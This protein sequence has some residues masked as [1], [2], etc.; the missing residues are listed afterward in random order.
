MSMLSV[1]VLCDGMRVFLQ[2]QVVRRHAVE[3]CSA[4][5]AS[6]V[7]SLVYTA[8]LAASLGLSGEIG[9]S[10][11]PRSITVALA[12][13]ISQTLGGVESLTAAMVCA[14]GLT[15]AA[16]GQ[17]VLGMLRVRDEISRGVA[18]ASSAHGLGASAMAASEPQALPFC[19][20]TIVIMGTVSNVLV[21]MP[22]F[23]SALQAVTG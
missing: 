15:G 6:S 13:P 3:I 11:L 18:Q 16:L 10:L 9:R 20:V 12:L 23:R 4:V 5:L 21:C 14:T 2:R 19:A 7:F 22:V 17:L 1:V 8:K